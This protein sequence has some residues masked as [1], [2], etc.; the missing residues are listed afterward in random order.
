MHHA[1]REEERGPAALRTHSGPEAL[2]HPTLPPFCGPHAPGHTAELLHSLC[3]RSGPLHCVLYED[4]TQKRVRVCQ[5]SPQVLEHTLHGDHS[6]A[7]GSPVGTDT[8]DITT[9]LWLLPMGLHLPL[10]EGLGGGHPVGQQ[11]TGWSSGWSRGLCVTPLGRQAWATSGPQGLA[12][13]AFHHQ[14]S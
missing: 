10:E 1:L 4:D 8:C 5:P 6:S 11:V 9:L 12:P 14:H 2:P 7:A 3:S 13:I